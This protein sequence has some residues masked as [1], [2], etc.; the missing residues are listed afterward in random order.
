ASLDDNGFENANPRARIVLLGGA[1]GGGG[2]RPA[3]A[4]RQPHRA[5]HQEEGSRETHRL[6]HNST[7]NPFPCFRIPH[8][9][10]LSRP[11]LRPARAVGAAA[12]VAS[13]QRSGSG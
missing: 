7:S 2:A 11:L 9:T 5:E 8:P 3:R 4:R 12:I 10:R 13:R 1:L 6:T